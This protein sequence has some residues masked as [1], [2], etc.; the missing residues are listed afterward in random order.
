[1]RDYFPRERATP[2]ID[3][4]DRPGDMHNKPNEMGLA[5]GGAKPS[6]RFITAR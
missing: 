2:D 1:V 3:S 5:P 4:F 6:N